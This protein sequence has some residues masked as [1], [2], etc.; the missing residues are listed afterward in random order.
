MSTFITIFTCIFMCMF[1]PHKKENMHMHMNTDTDTGMDTEKWTWTFKETDIE[2]MVN[3]ISDILSDFALYCTV[4]YL[5]FQCQAQSDIVHHG[6][7]TAWPM[8]T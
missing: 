3:P 1:M 5:K 2:K 7:R 6:Y 8:A 4:R